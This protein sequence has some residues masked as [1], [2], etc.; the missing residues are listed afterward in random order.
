M[1]DIA[2][3]FEARS[4]SEKAISKCCTIMQIAMFGRTDMTF[5]LLFSTEKKNS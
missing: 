4:W 5:M 3:L 2:L 1:F